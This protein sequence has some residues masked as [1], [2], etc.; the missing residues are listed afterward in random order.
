MKIFGFYLHFNF[1]VQIPPY[2]GHFYSMSSGVPDFLLVNSLSRF[3]FRSAADPVFPLILPV[4]FLKRCIP[5]P[6]KAILAVLRM[7]RFHEKRQ[8][9]WTLLSETSFFSCFEDGYI[10]RRP[11]WLTSRWLWSPLC[12][13]F[14]PD[15]PSA[16]CQSVSSLTSKRRKAPA[17]RYQTAREADPRECTG[18][19]PERQSWRSSSRSRNTAGL[20]TFPDR[21][22]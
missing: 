13:S 12:G 22:G 9:G 19:W 10:S 16:L 17:G 4:L 2:S 18:Q 5:D 11:L 20:C 21:S 8:Q 1:L 14:L 7:L 15:T 3:T 6:L